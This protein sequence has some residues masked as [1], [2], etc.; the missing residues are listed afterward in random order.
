[1][2]ASLFR[3][4]GKERPPK[5]VIFSDSISSLTSIQNGESSCR[6]DLL[7]SVLAKTGSSSLQSHIACTQNIRK[8]KQLKKSTGGRGGYQYRKTFGEAQGREKY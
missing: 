8:I 3:Y 5:A 2:A 7:S 1:M 6:Q 4:N